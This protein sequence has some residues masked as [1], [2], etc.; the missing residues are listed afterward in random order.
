MSSGTERR[1]ER[2]VPARVE[3]KWRAEW[4]RTH[5]HET[6]DDSA[7]P[8]YYFVTMFPY[9]SGDIH[10]GHWYAYAPSDCAARYMRMRGHNVLFPM[11]FDAFGI[12]AENA[13][14]DR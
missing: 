3:A 2:Y 6:P 9:P 5:A 11:G 4:E 8:N 13:A 1:T 12:K 14:I 10:V 7:L